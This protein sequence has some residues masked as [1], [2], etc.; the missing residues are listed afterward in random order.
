MAVRIK[1]IFCV[2]MV[3][4]LPAR[5]QSI[6]GTVR[7]AGGDPME[8]VHVLLPQTHRGAVTG[9]DGKYVIDQVAPGEHEIEF[10]HVGFGTVRSWVWVPEGGP[11]VMDVVMEPESVQLQSIVVTA[12]GHAG[13]MLSRATR[14]VAVLGEDD[15]RELQ[16]RSLGELLSRLPGVTTLS[17]GPSISKPVIRGLH[18]QRILVMQDG[19]GLEGQQWGGEHAPEIDPFS[20]SRIE[21]VKGAASVEYG[22]GAIGG[23]VRIDPADLPENSAVGGVASLR[24]Y[25]GNRQAAASI[26][27]EGG[28]RSVPG[29]GWR[30]RISGRRAGDSSTPDYVLG[31]T[32]FAELDAN[33]SVGYHRGRSGVH[34]LASRFSTEL[35]L[36]KGAHIGNV[37]DLLRAIERAQPLTEYDFTWDIAAP[38]QEI[39]HDVAL[40]R[41]HLG[42]RSGD[43]IEGHAG[44]Q[45]NRRAEYDAHSRN[46]DPSQPAFALDLLSQSFDLKFRARPRGPW[47]GVVGLSL[48]NQTN[49]NGESGFLIPNYHALTAGAFGFVS[50]VSRRWTHEAGL[51]VDLRRMEAWPR[52]RLSVGPF[53][54]RTHEW[55]AIS[56]NLGTIR[57]IGRHWSVAAQASI[58]WRPPGVN[59]LYNFGVH[60]GTAQFEVGDPDLGVERSRSGDL[61]VRHE[62]ERWMTEVSVFVNHIDGFIHLVPE[63]RPRVTIRGSFPSFRYG[64][65]D[66]LLTGF[67]AGMTVALGRGFSTETSLSVVRGTDR[68]ADRPLI[69]MPADRA[70]LRLARSVASGRHSAEI[71]VHATVV[72][73]QTRYPEGVDFA[74][75]P[76]AYRLIGLDA[77]GRIRTGSRT[78]D[79]TISADNLLNRSYRDYL[80]RYRYFVD[81]PGRTVTFGLRVPFGSAD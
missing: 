10:R 21:V 72:A 44:F 75:P 67:D 24:G 73:R 36:Y 22:A 9:P 57:K 70:R 59:E 17:T 47:L 20:A 64:H 80:S 60:H 42:L 56:A 29:L 16:G 52:E 30:A 2:L 8:G 33:L 63:S 71:G 65:S 77:T 40:L 12:E 43:V 31:N 5:A 74:E 54:R 37:D 23:V 13:A 32:G 78:V 41:G 34:V 66:A 45:A 25:T 18:S 28:P 61:T 49:R 1:A 76:A 14:S 46:G 35:G 11:G 4:A 51:R 38:R 81:D 58:A 68:Q 55:T 27:L 26:M 53:V 69:F 79:V 3:S 7:R 6:L 19:V 15:L 50:R 62:S 39:T 48:M